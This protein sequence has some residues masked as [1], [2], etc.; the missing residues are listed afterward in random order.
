MLSAGRTPIEGHRREQVLKSATKEANAAGK[1]LQETQLSGARDVLGYF[2]KLALFDG[3]AAALIITFIGSAR[4]SLAPPWG[5]KVGLILLL[6]GVVAAMLRNW[7][8][9]RYAA[10]VRL[11]DYLMAQ[12]KEQTARADFYEV[13]PNP[14]SLQNGNPLDPVQFRSEIEDSNEAISSKVKGLRK[15]Q[16]RSWQ[17][18][19]WSGTLAQVFTVLALAL[20]GYVA[21]VSL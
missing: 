8:Y 21:V 1:L 16:R 11:A 14:I 13:A 7:C 9:F 5:I 4:R 15:K 17:I 20:L 18:N 3:S 19:V 10:A 12:A 2:E 6:L